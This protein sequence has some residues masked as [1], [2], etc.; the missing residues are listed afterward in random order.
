MNLKNVMNKIFPY[1]IHLI[2]P[3]CIRKV[4]PNNIYGF[5]KLNIPN[6]KILSF[7]LHRFFHFQ[8]NTAETITEKKIFQNEIIIHLS[9]KIQMY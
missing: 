6:T 4:N 2:V 9:G 7:L 8:H 3:I 5:S 1:F